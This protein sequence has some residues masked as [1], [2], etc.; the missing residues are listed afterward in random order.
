[1][2]DENLPR[3]RLR[4]SPEPAWLLPVL[5]VVLALTAFAL[6]Y[7]ARYELQILRPVF[8]PNRAEFVPY[9]PYAA[10][11][12]LLLHLHFRGSGLYRNVRGRAW[13]EEAWAIANGITNATVILLGLFFVLQPLV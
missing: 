3:K 1:M 9:M 13:L 10:V 11:Y 5:D 8:D 4:R 2:T 7:V 12:V 6:A